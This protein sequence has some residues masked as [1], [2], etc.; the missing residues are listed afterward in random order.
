MIVKVSGV[1]LSIKF[2]GV[3]EIYYINPKDGK[4]TN[5]TMKDFWAKLFND[6]K[7]PICPICK[8]D[9]LIERINIER[10]AQVSYPIGATRNP[11][12]HVE[13]VIELTFRCPE[14]AGI[15][16]GVGEDINF[17]TPST[18]HLEKLKITRWTV[19][20]P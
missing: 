1:T 3:K 12:W 7:M 17:D 14:C 4:K 11:L 13:P 19:N 8:V 5:S 10:Q 9:L 2:K 15:V 16:E 18:F 6:Y 20:V